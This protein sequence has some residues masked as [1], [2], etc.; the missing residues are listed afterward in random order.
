MNENK[1]FHKLKVNWGGSGIEIEKGLGLDVRVSV[2]GSNDHSRGCLQHPT[3][4]EQLYF[5]F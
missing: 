1:T 4:D 5:P 2:H 3:V